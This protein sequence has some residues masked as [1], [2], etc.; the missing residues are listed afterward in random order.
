[1]L[2]GNKTDNETAS[3][4]YSPHHSFFLFALQ[5]FAAHA[6]SVLNLFRIS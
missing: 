6:L 3:V 4:F 1:M 5:L 2:D